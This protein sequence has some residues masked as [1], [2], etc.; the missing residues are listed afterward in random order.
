MIILLTILL[1]SLCCNLLQSVWL[2]CE[3]IKNV[4]L[5]NM[6]QG[7]LIEAAGTTQIDSNTFRLFA[8]KRPHH[9]A[10]IELLIEEGRVQEPCIGNGSASGKLSV[11]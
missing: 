8:W 2:R 1:I 6:V 9:K 5:V 4:A 11:A 7:L 3:R 10:A